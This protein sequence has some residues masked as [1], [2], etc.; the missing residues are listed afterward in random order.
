MRYLPLLIVIL[1]SGCESM[2]KLSD[3]AKCPPCVYPTSCVDKESDPYIRID[4]SKLYAQEMANGKVSYFI[5]QY[6]YK[7]CGVYAI[8]S[9]EISKEE[10]NELSK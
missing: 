4:E 1:M 2:A 9:K 3:T 8:G 6:G 7:R 5:M 10:W